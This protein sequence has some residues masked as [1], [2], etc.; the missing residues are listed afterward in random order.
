[1]FSFLYCI[2]SLT[3]LN[4]KVPVRG[5]GG[6]VD[7]GKVV[8]SSLYYFR[9]VCYFSDVVSKFNSLSLEVREITDVLNVR[10]F[11]MVHLRRHFFENIARE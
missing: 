8:S 6:V 9:S 3:R 11:S 7:S 2:I 4:I 10:R 5:M 1:M